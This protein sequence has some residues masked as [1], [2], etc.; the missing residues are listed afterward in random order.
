[1]PYTIFHAIHNILIDRLQFL[2]IILIEREEVYVNVNVQKI[3]GL[4]V[5]SSLTPEKDQHL[6]TQL[7]SKFLTK[8]ASQHHPQ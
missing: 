3:Y 8:P 5:K 1:M 7:N 6:L 2:I 4:F